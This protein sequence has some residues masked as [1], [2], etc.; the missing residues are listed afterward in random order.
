MSWYRLGYAD[1]KA[2]RY[3]RAEEAWGKFLALESSSP[4]AVQVKKDLKAIEKKGDTY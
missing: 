3:D 2:G 4:R 1:L